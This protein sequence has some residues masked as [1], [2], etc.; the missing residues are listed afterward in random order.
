M[1]QFWVRGLP[2]DCVSVRQVLSSLRRE[3]PVLP[4][5]MRRDWLKE[6]KGLKGFVTED[7]H[8][9]ENP[10]VIFYFLIVIGY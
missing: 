10:I 9:G 1:F 6:L 5:T 8:P 7:N 4:E 2:A 3:T